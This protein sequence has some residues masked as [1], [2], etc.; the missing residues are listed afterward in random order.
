MSKAKDS[1]GISI[2]EDCRSL[3]LIGFRLCVF[4]L[5]AAAITNG[6]TPAPLSVP[7]QEARWL[8]LLCRVCHL[9]WHRTLVKYGPWPSTKLPLFKRK[10]LFSFLMKRLALGLKTTGLRVASLTAAKAWNL[11]ETVFLYIPTAPPPHPNPHSSSN[12]TGGTEAGWECEAAPQPLFESGPTCP[13]L[14]SLCAP[15]THNPMYA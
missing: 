7:K 10:K 8:L 3:S 2:G 1:F 11:G 5:E 12:Q 9:G 15:N 14:L 4:H 6:M 13:P